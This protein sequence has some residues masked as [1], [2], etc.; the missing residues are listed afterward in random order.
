MSALAGCDDPPK[1][2]AVDPFDG[3][4]WEVH[5]GTPTSRAVDMVLVIDNSYGNIDART[6]LSEQT[7]ILE[8]LGTLDSGMPDLHVGVITSDLG[9]AP[10][11]IAG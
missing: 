6:Y 7:G 10:Y 3:L 2:T 8:A 9:S 4:D 11:N 1:K 5:P